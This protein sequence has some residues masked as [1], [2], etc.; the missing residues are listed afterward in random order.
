MT[1][2]CRLLTSAILRL[3]ASEALLER[4]GDFGMEDQLA[5]ERLGDG[6]AREVVFGRPEAAGEDHD[7]GAARPRAGS[8]RPAGRGRRR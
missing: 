8:R 5:V 6:L 2:A 1:N 4:L 7:L 3:A